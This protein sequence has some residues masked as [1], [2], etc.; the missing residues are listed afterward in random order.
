M[1]KN[2]GYTIS[3]PPIT[4]WIENRKFFVFKRLNGVQRNCKPHCVLLICVR[5]VEHLYLQYEFLGHIPNRVIHRGRKIVKNVVKIIENFK[6]L[7]EMHMWHENKGVCQFWG[8][9]QIYKLFTSFWSLLPLYWHLDF[10][11]QV[12]ANESTRNR[13]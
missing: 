12:K 11:W 4:H 5:L 8:E 9:N 3:H 6:K 10:Y 1:E 13:K 2:F 7:L